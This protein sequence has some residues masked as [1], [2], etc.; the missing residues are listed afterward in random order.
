MYN[1]DR[2]SSNRLTTDMIMDFPRNNLCASLFGKKGTKYKAANDTVDGD[3]VM[4]G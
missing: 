1:E 4:F 3:I 2:V